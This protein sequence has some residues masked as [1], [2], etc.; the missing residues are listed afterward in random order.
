MVS[1]TP[2]NSLS[3]IQFAALVL[4]PVLGVMLAITR[5]KKKAGLK[6]LIVGLVGSVVGIEVVLFGSQAIKLFPYYADK[7]GLH[8][9]QAFIAAGVVGIGLL[10]HYFKKRN[11]YL[12]GLVEIAFGAGSALSISIGMTPGD[13]LFSRWA[14]LA[15]CAYVVARGANNLSEAKAKELPRLKFTN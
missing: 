10:A 9:L 2:P 11:Q 13:I 3:P 7:F 6:D 5:H 15:G 8:R 14:A 12:Y 4:A 1:D